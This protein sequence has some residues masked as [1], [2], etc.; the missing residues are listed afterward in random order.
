LE[1]Y[2]NF[3]FGYSGTEA[4]SEE[5][6]KIF[7]RTPWGVSVPKSHFVALYND[8]WATG[9]NGPD[10]DYNND[11]TP[12]LYFITIDDAWAWPSID[13]NAS[14]ASEDKVKLFSGTNYIRI[15]WANSAWD[16]STW[17][18]SCESWDYTSWDSASYNP[19][20]AGRGVWFSSGRCGETALFDKPFQ[21][22]TLDMNS[23]PITYRTGWESVCDVT[24]SYSNGTL[25]NYISSTNSQMI[26]VYV[27]K[28]MVGY[29]NFRWSYGEVT[30]NE[31]FNVYKRKPWWS[32]VEPYQL[33]RLWNAAGTWPNPPDWD[34]DND[35]TDDFEKWFYPDAS[36]DWV[37]AWHDVKAGPMTFF[38]GTNYMRIDG[39]LS[40]CEGLSGWWSVGFD[41][42]TAWA[43]GRVWITLD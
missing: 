8:G 32:L 2:I 19:N 6:L 39:H 21:D 38:K 20:T 14:I 1:A 18:F 10:L 29:L 37:E 4:E 43:E 15:E 42:V 7:L 36:N 23:W 11:G 24:P 9:T 17:E 35:G 25:Q 41:S 28:T 30:T 5:H 31:A 34:Y 27:P 3:T 33:L 13:K 26:A 12:D 40:Y 16:Y 22:A